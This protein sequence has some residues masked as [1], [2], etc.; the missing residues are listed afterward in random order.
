MFIDN[1]VSVIQ[2]IL[3]RLLNTSDWKNGS[4]VYE[5]ASILKTGRKASLPS[6]NLWALDRDGSWEVDKLVRFCIGRKMKQ[7]GLKGGRIMG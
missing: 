1:Q 7:N 4:F 3:N 5:A 6:P 2:M